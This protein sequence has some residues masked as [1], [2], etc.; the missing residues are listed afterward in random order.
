MSLE[1]VIPKAKVQTLPVSKGWGDEEEQV[2][3]LSRAVS[4]VSGGPG[5]LES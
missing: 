4:E 2:K 3:R 1:E 5:G